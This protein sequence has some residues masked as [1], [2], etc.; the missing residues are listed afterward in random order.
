[1]DAFGHRCFRTGGLP[2]FGA[3]ALAILCG[4]VSVVHAQA[5]RI[6]WT[7]SITA[8]PPRPGFIGQTSMA[9]TPS[10]WF[11]RLR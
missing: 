10:G 9:V 1:M 11:C 3:F 2:R 7:D 6:Y 5:G 8:A 4:N